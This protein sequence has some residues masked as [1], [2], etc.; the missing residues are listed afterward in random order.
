MF[1][2]AFLTAGIIYSCAGCESTGSA[3]VGLLN[4]LPS[5][6]YSARQQTEL[7]EFIAETVDASS[8]N[9]QNELWPWMVLIMVVYGVG[10]LSS[11]IMAFSHHKSIKKAVNGAGET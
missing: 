9:I 4:F 3:G 1:L 11:T 2:W 6:S 5:R 7:R 10:K 8:Q